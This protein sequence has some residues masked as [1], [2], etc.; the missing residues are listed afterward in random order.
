[1]VIRFAKLY[2]SEYSVRSK[3]IRRGSK[4]I[5][6]KSE[7]VD[8]CKFTCWT[9]LSLFDLRNKGYQNM[10]QID[11]ETDRLYSIGREESSD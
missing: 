10:S 6:K 5:V 2:G 9:I 7:L 1:M 4:H 11:K 8:M 3:I